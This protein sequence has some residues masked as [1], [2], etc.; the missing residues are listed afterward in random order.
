MGEIYSHQEHRQDAGL[1]Y[2]NVIRSELLLR[3]EEFK[4]NAIQLL[5]FQ[6]KKRKK[7]KVSLH[8]SLRSSSLIIVKNLVDSLFHL[9]ALLPALCLVV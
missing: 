5:C 7:K 9:T 6:R 4:V 8:V 2:S 3:H 1:P